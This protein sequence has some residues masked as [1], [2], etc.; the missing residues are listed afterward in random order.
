MTLGSV[1][2]PRECGSEVADIISCVN[3]RG[4]KLEKSQEK[5]WG[6]I[7]SCQVNVLLTLSS[8]P[9]TMGSSA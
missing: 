8:E 3:V 5:Q 2:S 1:L 6:K 4:K 9:I 7:V